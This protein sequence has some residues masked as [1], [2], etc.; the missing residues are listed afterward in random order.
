MSV[1]LLHRCMG[2]RSCIYHRSASIARYLSCRFSLVITIRWHQVR[3]NTVPFTTASVDGPVLYRTAFITWSDSGW[4]V[5]GGTLM[6]CG[7]CNKEFEQA[8]YKYNESLA[9][10]RNRFLPIVFRTHRLL[11]DAGAARRVRVAVP[12]ASNRIESEQDSPAVDSAPIRG[13]RFTNGHKKSRHRIDP[14]TGRAAS[15]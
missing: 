14:T 2:I 15:F 7:H 4:A 11:Q 3:N 9:D 6:P 5:G 8:L 1:F 10:L 13:Q 12:L